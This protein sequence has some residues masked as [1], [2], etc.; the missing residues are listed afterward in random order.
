MRSGRTR[1]TEYRRGFTLAELLIVVAIIAVLVAVSVPIFAAQLDKSRQAVDLTNARAAY[2]AALNEWMTTN[3]SGRVIYYY[4]GAG[5]RKS[6]AGIKGYGKSDTKFTNFAAIDNF[7]VDKSRLFGT[8]NSSGG[9]SYISV[10][11]NENGVEK[12]GW[13]APGDADYLDAATPLAAYNNDLTKLKVVDNKDRVAA[14]QQTLRS[15]GEAILAKG[16]TKEEFKKLL[17]I[18]AK[19]SS[20]SIMRIADYRLTKTESGDEWKSTGFTISTNKSNEL[21]KIMEDMGY[22]GGKVTG[23]GERTEGDRNQYKRYDTTYTNS[24]FYSDELATNKFNNNDISQTKR[25]IILSNI[26]YDSNDKIIGFTILSKAMDE[27]ANLTPAQ[28]AQFEITIP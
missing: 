20:D 27:E 11:M 6:S 5:V 18:D 17:K 10:V 7:P 26:Q 15:I 24:L 3:H 23:T 16:Y 25:S 1:K 22:D 13:G 28:K 12:L 14:D 21:L 8:P 4:D 9:P 2:A 19:G